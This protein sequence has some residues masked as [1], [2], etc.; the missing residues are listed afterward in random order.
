MHPNLER[1]SEVLRA[2]AGSEIMP[3]FHHAKSSAKA[4]G[5]LVT[6]TDAAA[7]SSIA[8][9]LARAYPG[10]PLLGEEM[11][12]GEQAR[13]LGAADQA[14]WVL[15]PVDGTSNYAG[16]YPGFAVSLALLEG[17]QVVQGAVLDP[18][19][20]ECFCAIR[21]GGAWCN[22]API[23]PF[24]PGPSLG[25]CLA[26]VDFKRL[27]P[28]RIAALFRPGGF[29]SQRNLGASALEWCWL[30]AGR[31]QL[32]LHG[33]Q[34]LWDY[35]AGQLIAVEAGAAYRG[36]RPY[37]TAAAAGIDLEPRLQV[38]AATPELLEQWLAFIEL[39]FTRP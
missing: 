26:M 21:G 15:D 32:Y 25:D 22:G 24:A 10:I 27:P 37:G 29:R 34:K 28:A 8:A 36:Y 20:D 7:Q 11:S 33:G 3:R 12:E 18:V 38:A 17:G 39:P 14:V 4:D 30:A 35:A 13:L 5:S 1:L 9:A 19:R 6:E 31:F 16:G 23:A 2:A